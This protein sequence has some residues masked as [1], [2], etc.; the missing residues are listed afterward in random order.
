MS[1]APRLLLL[2]F[3]PFPSATG[4]ATRLAQRI[5][6]F[7]EAGYVLDVLSPKTPELPHVSKLMG[8][9]IL[10]VPMPTGREPA[11]RAALGTPSPLTTTELTLAAPNTPASRLFAFDRAVRRQ[12]L[13][14]EYDVIHTSE[15]YSGLTVLELKNGAK[16]VYEAPAAVA[17]AELDTEL[18]NDLRRHDRELLRGADAVIVPSDELGTRAWGLG[19]ERS[20]VHVVRPSTDLTMFAPPADRRHRSGASLN[21]VLVAAQLSSAET[22]LLLETLE[23]IPPTIDL[24]VELSAALSPT[25]RQRFAASPVAHR[26]RC[27]EPV[28]YE[29]LG[30]L[31]ERADV[32]LVIDAGPVL[33]QVHPV[34]FQCVAEMLAAGLAMILPDTEAV[35]EVIEHD[36]H[37]VLVPSASPEALAK[38]IRGLA[39]Q[40][41]RRRVLSRNAR[42]RAT[43]LFDEQAAA[44]ATLAIYQSMLMPPSMSVTSPTYE[45]ASGT[46]PTGRRD[47]TRGTPSAQR[48]PREALATAA[49]PEDPPTAPDTSASA[50]LEDLTTDPSALRSGR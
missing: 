27:I 41:T 49:V 48:M 21:L 50:L 10:R 7:A 17:T 24:V 16:V 47:P 43:E 13:S 3:T 11:P 2:S 12:L 15:A 33:G 6:A 30:P 23:A 20:R 45:L 42:A 44:A 4:A 38:A 28:L 29:D 5:A 39:N 14:N 37:G 46:S 19:A 31:Y 8:S 26:I 36:K 22:S 34:R 35:R 32:G 1:D 40:P 18:A 9:R 25:D